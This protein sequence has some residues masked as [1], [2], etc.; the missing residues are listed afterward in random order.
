MAIYTTTSRA[1]LVPVGDGGWS[2]NWVVKNQTALLCDPN[3]DSVGTLE[4]VW[5]EG[6]RYG[7]Q[8]TPDAALFG[9][10]F[11]TWESAALAAIERFG[12]ARAAFPPSAPCRD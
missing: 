6:W 7:L 9:H 3:G 11:E 4:R 10:G 12:E 1:K 8:V 2:I 5:N